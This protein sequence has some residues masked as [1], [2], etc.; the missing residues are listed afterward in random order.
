VVVI[1]PDYDSGSGQ[2]IPK[3]EP[4]DT[5]VNFSYYV[6]KSADVSGIYCLLKETGSTAGTVTYSIFLSKDGS[7]L[8]NGSVS[9]TIPQANYPSG[10]N[11]I[12]RKRK[13]FYICG[14]VSDSV[15]LIDKE[16]I[17]TYITLDPGESPIGGLQRAIDGR[18]VLPFTRFDGSIVPYVWADKISSHTFTM[19]K[20]FELQIA[21][22]TRELHSHVRMLGAYVEAEYIHDPLIDI[23]GSRFTEAN[24]PYLMTESEC[25]AEAKN[26]VRR[27]LEAAEQASFRS[28]YMPFLEPEDRITIEGHGDWIVNSIAPQMGYNVVWATYSVRRWVDS[29]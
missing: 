20:Y 13:G 5:A 12:E 3:F 14:N 9:V 27:M 21:K 28:T 17:P 4:A 1:Y 7:T 10:E 23:V 29:V 6:L 19:D 8:Y 18:Y 16:N 22:D 24:N 11:I 26:Q 15:S 25:Y 2:W